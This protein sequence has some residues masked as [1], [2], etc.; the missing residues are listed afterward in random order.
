MI[1]VILTNKIEDR[2]DVIANLQYV[3]SNAMFII[4][5]PW[6]FRVSHLWITSILFDVNMSCRFFSMSILVTWQSGTYI[7]VW[8]IETKEKRK[9]P[10]ENT[11]WKRNVSPHSRENCFLEGG[12]SYQFDESASTFNIYKQVI[13]LDVL[14]EILVRQSNFYS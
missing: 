4:V 13:N 10:E 8:R 1:S 5:F 7:K 11:P 14:I 12:V 6:S 9:K 2:Y 3:F